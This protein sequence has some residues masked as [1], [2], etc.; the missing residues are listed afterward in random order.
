MRNIMRNSSS[1]G[2]KKRKRAFTRSPFVIRR[3]YPLTCQVTILYS[4]YG[5]ESNLKNRENECNMAF[6]VACINSL[7]MSDYIKYSYLDN[8]CSC[9]GGRNRTFSFQSTSLASQ[10]ERQLRAPSKVEFIRR[11]MGSQSQ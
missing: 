6:R 7:D 10:L 2:I 11:N 4:T 5:D 1:I 3:F 8:R 9:G